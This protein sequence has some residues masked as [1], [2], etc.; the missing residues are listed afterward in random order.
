MPK[1]KKN[2][3]SENLEE[4]TDIA[5]II[6]GA[7]GVLSAFFFGVRCVTCNYYTE[8]AFIICYTIF[9][10]SAE[11]AIMAEAIKLVHK[12]RQQKRATD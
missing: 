7:F 9:V 3:L 5:M 4:T 6:V 8:I 11:T 2:N 10:L 12:H 1:N